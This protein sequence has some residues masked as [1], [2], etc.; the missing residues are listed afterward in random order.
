ME[1]EK[2]IKSFSKPIIIGISLIIIGA[3]VVYFYGG[4]YSEISQT[5]RRM[6]PD[7]SLKDHLGHPH[8]LPE[9]RGKVTLVHFWA[10][11]CPPCL[12]EIPDLIEF[13]AKWTEK[14]PDKPIQVFAISLDEKWEDAEKVVTTDKLPKDMTSLLDLTAKVPDTYGTYQYPETYLIDK[15]GRIVTKW[16]GA[17]PWTSL[18]MEKVLLEVLNSPP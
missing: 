18:G 8:S 10:S 16:I 4:P 9:A 12:Q 5:G 1:T 13:A 14:Y 7:F 3:C 2:W 15:N 17:Q 6:A 11:W